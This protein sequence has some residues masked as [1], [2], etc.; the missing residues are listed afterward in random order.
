MCP[1]KLSCTFAVATDAAAAQDPDVRTQAQQLTQFPETAWG[2][3]AVQA[4]VV[5]LWDLTAGKSQ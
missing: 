4:V 5:R 3:A 2:P 1:F